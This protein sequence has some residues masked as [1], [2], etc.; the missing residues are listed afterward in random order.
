MNPFQVLGLPVTATKADIVERHRQLCEVTPEDQH[1]P[2][3]QARRDLLTNPDER[4]MHEV[5]EI[6]ATEYQERE[7][8]W[9]RFEHRHR[10]AA[11]DLTALRHSAQGLRLDD[12]DLA[13]V[14]GLLLDELLT[15]PEVDIH[16]ALAEVPAYENPQMMEIRD[17]LFG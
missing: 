14:I 10:R 16:R 7:R 15:L 6:P 1:P 9:R 4:R 13:G 11:V 3:H 8:T 2:F 5:L 17:V 12:V